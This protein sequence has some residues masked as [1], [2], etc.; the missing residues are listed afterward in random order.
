VATVYATD[1]ASR[2]LLGEYY[3]GKSDPVA[4]IAPLEEASAYVSA[5]TPVQQNLVALLATAYLQAGNRAAEKEVWTEAAD[6]YEKLS[7][8]APAELQG[9]AGCANACVQLR[10]FARAARALEKMASL[11][12]GNPTIFLSLGDVLHQDGRDEAA[13]RNWTKAKGLV[14]A[15]DNELMAA[16]ER[17]LNGPLTPDL[18]Q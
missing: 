17:R 12:P 15:G 13:R 5:G 11:E 18:F 1:V 14:A 6:Y 4:A 2:A 8:A 7:R 10:Q 9:Y 16:L 3:L